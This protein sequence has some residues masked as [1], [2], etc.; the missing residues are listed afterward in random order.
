VR[1]GGGTAR[2]RVRDADGACV[3]RRATDL[4]GGLGQR[5]RQR[6]STRSLLWFPIT[7]R[8]AGPQPPTSAS[9]RAWGQGAAAG[10]R[11]GCRTSRG[12][13][14]VRGANCIGRRHSSCS[15]S[16]PRPPA[17]H[18]PRLHVSDKMPGKKS[19]TS[20]RATRALSTE[21]AQEAQPQSTSP[22]AA[23]ATP[24]RDAARW[25]LE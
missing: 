3:R 16:P 12:H 23:K 21:G 6:L 20:A 7:F 25:D 9:P 14:S 11:E 15:P 1:A 18:P 13:R 19:R 5:A 17:M 10:S 2:A 24:G 22:T 4:G 8:D